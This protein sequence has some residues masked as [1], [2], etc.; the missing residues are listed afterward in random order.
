MTAVARLCDTSAC[1]ALDAFW[2]ASCVW[3]AISKC[4]CA[5]PIFDAL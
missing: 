2:F 1:F 4:N 5:M 3:P